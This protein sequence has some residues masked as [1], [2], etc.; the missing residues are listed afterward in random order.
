[1][2]KQ[3]E[4]KRK[5]NEREKA[6]MEENTNQFAIAA[7]EYINRGWS[8]IP[9]QPPEQDNS[10]SGKKPW[11]VNWNC[12]LSKWTQF[13]M[14]Q[15]RIPEIWNAETKVN[16]G[17]LTGKASGIVVLDFD[18]PGIFEEW[19]KLHPEAVNTYT[20]QRDNA[21]ADRCH[22]YFSIPTT[23]YSPKSTKDLGWDLQ[24][25]GRQVVAPPS[26]HYSGGIYQCVKDIPLL[27]WDDSYLEGLPRRK[28]SSANESDNTT[29]PTTISSGAVAGE[30]NNKAFD[31]SC[32]LRDSK[33][34]QSEAMEHLKIFAA[35]CIP[36]LP[37]AE[38]IA[39]VDSA[40]SHPARPSQEAL[41]EWVVAEKGYILI[42]RSIF[43]L[44]LLPEYKLVYLYLISQASFRD[45]PHCKLGQLLTN[46][47]TISKSL[48]I[49]SGKVKNIMRKLRDDGYIQSVKKKY[50]SLITINN[51]S[52][53]QNKKSYP[54]S[55]LY[56][57]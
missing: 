35:S 45:R 21:P 26:I 3:K 8:I 36:P 13:Y 15:D 16:I 34:P 47:E 30:R 42:Q 32:K 50:L 24:A 52:A 9:I 18:E 40:Y 20:V 37:Q 17:V 39:T 2:L 51:Y 56:S 57:M 25:D 48:R 19:S 11:N 29:I 12:Q 38:A 5:M 54:F 44:Q 41:P 33:L 46:Y 7:E 22:L 49:D 55:S 27:P 14:N 4:G 31:F 28:S 6:A 1:M 43:D 10:K 53:L 23:G